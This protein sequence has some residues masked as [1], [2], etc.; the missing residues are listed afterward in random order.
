M[1]EEEKRD[2][3]MLKAG[4]G[5][6]GGG[7]GGGCVGELHSKKSTALSQPEEPVVNTDQITSS[8]PPQLNPPTNTTI[9]RIWKY[10]VCGYSY[11]YI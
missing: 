4:E 2:G 10:M 3:N 9:I 11:T 8:L 7:G 6:G 5:G 1:R